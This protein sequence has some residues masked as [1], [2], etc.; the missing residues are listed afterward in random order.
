[1]TR[2]NS[3]LIV[4]DN[5]ADVEIAEY[6]LRKTGRVGQVFSVADGDEALALFKNSDAARHKH[7]GAFPP[8]VLLLDIHM[9]RMD[10]FEFLAAF[11]KLERDEDTPSIVLM[12][13]SSRHEEDRRRAEGFEAV[14]ECLTKPLQLEDAEGLVDRFGVA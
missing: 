4:D 2:I 1:M 14:K 12:L 11:S 13:A 10:G 3:L 5:P 7:P 9:P 8:R 6:Y